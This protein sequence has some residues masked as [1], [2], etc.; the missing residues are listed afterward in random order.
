MLY[1][2]TNSIYSY[3]LILLV[4]ILCAELPNVTNGVYSYNT[5]FAVGDQATYKCMYGS[6]V[7][8]STSEAEAKLTCTLQA[9]LI[10]V[11]WSDE[12]PSC[13]GLSGVNECAYLSAYIV[14]HKLIFRLYYSCH[15]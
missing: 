11:R 8:G 13:I 2:L 7:N 12:H 14:W 10:T 9:D 15:L 3:K 4:A 6:R 1:W 5:G